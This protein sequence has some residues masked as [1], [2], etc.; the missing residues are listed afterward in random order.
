MDNE[1]NKKEQVSKSTKEFTN[2]IKKTLD[3]EE[4]L[5]FGRYFTVT[6]VSFLLL[7][8]I[9]IVGLLITIKVN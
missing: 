3:T 5:V 2:T 9:V 4:L 6:I 8:V 1:Q 7:V